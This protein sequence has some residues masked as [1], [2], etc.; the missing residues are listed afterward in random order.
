MTCRAS[1]A[2]PDLPAWVARLDRA[3]GL[4]HRV[5]TARSIWVALRP[6]D[7]SG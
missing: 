3:A 6:R 7:G 5:L 1:G 2:A 4:D